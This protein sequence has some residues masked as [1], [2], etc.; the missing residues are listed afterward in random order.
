MVEEYFDLHSQGGLST[1]SDRTLAKLGTGKMD[2]ESLNELLRRVPGKHSS[3]CQQMYE[4]HRELFHKWMFY[5]W[6]V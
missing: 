6:Y 1:T 5:M 4:E 3:E 2:Q